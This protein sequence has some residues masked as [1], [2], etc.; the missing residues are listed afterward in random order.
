MIL[1]GI[2]FGPVC[3]ASGVRNFDKSGWWY[4]KFLWLLGLVFT[5]SSFVT[6]TTTLQPRL[7]TKLDPGGNMPLKKDGKT[8]K[9]WFP[10]CVVVKWWIGV[11]LNA[12]GLSGP[13]LFALLQKGVWQKL[14]EP[15]MISF[16]SVKEKLSHRLDEAIAFAQAIRAERPKFHAKFGIQIN[17]SCPNVG[18]K[19]ITEDEFVEEAH[20]LLE[21]ISKLLPGVPLIVKLSITTPVKTARRIANHR[22]CDAICVSNTVFWG[23]LPERIN[24]KKIFGTDISPLEKYGGGGLSGAPLL[25]LVEEWVREATSTGFPKPINAGGG[26]LS[27]KDAIRLLDAGATSIFIGSVAFLRPWRVRGIIKAAHKYIKSQALKAT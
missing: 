27:K 16:M 19:L 12:V 21:A 5:G 9:K 7:G 3:D 24:W 8:P 26:I 10:D 1:K 11:A 20:T 4:H 22:A 14:R 13:G 23:A 2:N 17:L 25:P 18:K 15:F 6:K